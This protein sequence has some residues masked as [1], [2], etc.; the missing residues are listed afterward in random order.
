MNISLKILESNS[1]IQQSIMEALLPQ[2]NDYMK[3]AITT[4]RKEIGTIISNAIV[5][6]PEYESL[7]SGKLKYELGIPDANAKIAGLLDI[8]TKNIYI[9][10]MPP[11]I[12]SSKIK[13][14]FSASLIKSSFDDVLS[15]DLAYVIDNIYQYRLP[16]LEWLLLEGN[17]II[18]KKQEVVMGP[19]PRS[20]TGFALMRG[21]NK[22]WKVPAEFAGTIRDNW[23]TRAIDNTE[24]EINNLLER[25]LQQ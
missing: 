4:I 19:N 21:S 15:T 16:W 6:T 3:D 10:Y 20:R 1:Q 9:E 23:I 11:K 18:V 8:W 7:V 22:N 24:A 13:S 2:I 5:N 25:A 14:S 12:I 17:K